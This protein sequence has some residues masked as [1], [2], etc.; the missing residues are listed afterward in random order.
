MVIGIHNGTRSPHESANGYIFTAV[1][2][3][4][5]LV[6]AES[7]PDAI[8]KDPKKGDVLPRCHRKQSVIER[9]FGLDEPADLKDG[10]TTENKRGWIVTTMDGLVHCGR[11]KTPRA[12][13]EIFSAYSHCLFCSCQPL[14]VNAH[15]LLHDHSVDDKG[16]AC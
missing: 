3:E 16:T 13:C 10:R 6:V 2:D 11:D 9:T 8:Q 7:L 4:A 5:H 15:D 14:P 12:R 1:S